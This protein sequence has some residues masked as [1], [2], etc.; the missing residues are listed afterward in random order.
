[1][2]FSKTLAA[3]LPYFALGMLAA[4]LAHGRAIEM[5]TKRLLVMAGVYDGSLPSDPARSARKRCVS[6][7]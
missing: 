1:M 3:M 4:L 2:T 6:G 7:R 5:A